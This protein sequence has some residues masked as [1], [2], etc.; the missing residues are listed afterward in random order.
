MAVGIT[1]DKKLNYTAGLDIQEALK[2]AKILKKELAE[3]GVGMAPNFKASQLALQDALKRS[4]LELQELKK[5]EQELKNTRAQS[6]A[7]NAEITKKINEN[8]LA[9]QQLTAAARAA[10]TA[11]VAVSGSYKEA[12]ERL[13]AL[14]KEIRNTT[15]GFNSQ[16]PALKAKVKEYNELNTR[17]KAF[18]TQL[19]NHQRNVGNYGGALKGALG[20]LTALASGYIAI[21]AI[22]QKSFTTS[23]KLDSI[24]KSLE[25]TFGSADLA[26]QR[27][28]VLRS[29]AERL[30]LEY[31]SLADTYRS[32]AGAAKASNFPMEEADK[33]FNAVA[34]AGAKLSLSSDEVKGS[35][36]ALQQMISKGNVQAEELRG[37]LGE[38]LP[39]AFSIAARSMGV[40]EQELGKLLEKGEVLAADL[41]PK[42]ADELNKTFGADQNQRIETLQSSV[43]RLENTFSAA[44]ESGNIGSFFKA[45]VDGATTSVVF[46][47]KLISKIRE[48]SYDKAI[49]NLQ[50]YQA[51][52]GNTPAPFLATKTGNILISEEAALEEIASRKQEKQLENR[53]KLMKIG[54]QLAHDIIIDN[55]VTAETIASLTREQQKLANIEQKRREAIKDKD[56]KSINQY[57]AALIQQKE[58]VKALEKEYAKPK[59]II[60]EA[61]QKKLDAAAKRIADRLAKDREK[62]LAEAKKFQEEVGK[63]EEEQ[64]KATLSAREKEEYEINKKYADLLSREQNTAMDIL[65]IKEANAKALS[66]M[67][68]KFNEE[69]KKLAKAAGDARFKAYKEDRD[70]YQELLASL[71]GYEEQRKNLVAKYAEQR[72]QLAADG[73]INEIA[74]LDQLEKAALGSLD[75]Q[76]VKKLDAYKAL[77]ADVEGLS[78]AA[79]QKIAAD[80]KSMLDKLVA[81]GKISAEL[82]KEIAEQLNKTT[83][84]LGLRLPDD[85]IRLG[86]ELRNLSGVVGGIDEQ[87]GKVI[88]TIA[89]VIGGVGDFGKQIQGLK[90]IKADDI[91]GQISSTIGL[92][93]TGLRILS[94]VYDTVSGFFSGDTKIEASIIRYKKRVDDLTTSFDILKGRISDS[95]GDDLYANQIEQI[96]ILT[97]KIETLNKAYFAEKGKKNADKG[98]LQGYLDQIRE[99]EQTIKEINAN[100]AQ[101][102]IQTNF[103]DLASTFAESL[104]TAYERIGNAFRSAGD[105]I[106]E[107]DEAFDKMVQSAIKNSLKMQILEPVVARFTAAL[108]DYA[109]ANN[110]S[111][112]GFD[113]EEWQ[114][115]LRF[116]GAQ[117]S[118]ALGASGKFFGVATADGPDKFLKDLGDKYLKSLENSDLAKRVEEYNKRV[119][120]A[121]TKG[122]SATD[123]EA[124]KKEFD[125]LAAIALQK[126]DE[127]FKLT[128]Q[129]IEIDPLTL[130]VSVEKIDTSAFDNDVKAIKDKLL[131]LALDSQDIFKDVNNS[132][133]DQLKNNFLA[134]LETGEY[135][136]AAKAYQKRFNELATIGFTTADVSSLKA[137][138]DAL[139]AL[140]QEKIKEYEKVTGQKIT[141]EITTPGP[142]IVE[143]DVQAKDLGSKLFALITKSAEETG[144]AIEDILKQSI[145]EGLQSKIITD[146]LKPLAEKVKGLYA[147][148]KTP[149]KD[150]IAALTAEMTTFVDGAKAQLKTLQEVTGLTFG[151]AVK[152]QIEEAAKVV[153]TELKSF[154]D[155]MINMFSNVEGGMSEFEANWDRMVQNTILKKLQTSSLEDKL[156]DFYENFNKLNGVEDSKKAEQLALLKAQYDRII[157]DGQ[158]EYE[159]LQ[160][161]FGVVAPTKPQDQSAISSSIGR[162]ITEDTANVLSGTFLGI[163]DEV[164]RSSGWLGKIYS[165]STQ[166]LTIQAAIEAGVRRTANNT[167]NLDAKLDAIER[168]TRPK[169]STNLTDAYLKL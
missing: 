144:A 42:L 9:Q 13:T 33:I 22:L 104:V 12:Q 15:N 58:I 126:Q 130:T 121:T 20:Q 28:D 39:G 109:R 145:L 168:N 91:F 120:E 169:S 76:N 124:F 36:L 70:K 149:T 128:G 72:A 77:Y 158:A 92:V 135:A 110:N 106:K 47:E 48:T 55:K 125:D 152:E 150:E 80:G 37:Q 27:M 26:A 119:A 99:A 148:G 44:V 35:L 83:S 155:S 123:V 100:I 136:D 134:S 116:A 105:P 165:I 45:I 139:A 2:Q 64:F 57:N 78:K 10:R 164:K 49:N 81:S 85:L 140:A 34:N 113:F 43:N 46:I 16:T 87:F 97:S 115:Q 166:N 65:R 69:D 162:S 103:K 157:R 141:P 88:G 114:R 84:V 7:D 167:D 112:L 11:N 153:D 98:A 156:T 60:S 29:T 101:G 82:A 50:K 86:S 90:K 67:N 96:Q 17:L 52:N 154:Q 107:F 93:T 147:N 79:V 21:G 117:F 1:S 71:A 63:I 66:L 62:E 51:K 129:K 95:I 68:D 54:Q 146:T 38:R 23:I 102:L 25:F 75:D 8:R 138:Y 131:Q 160:D 89:D 132:F 5:A 6:I 40:T 74:V 143:V 142:V 133:T 3:L 41:L 30:G 161:V 118:T 122:L 151:E 18:D 4:R 127:F 59:K 111:V 159:R 24:T 19:G 53:N 73:K 61:E 94:S 56:Q 32:F 137:Q 14:G 31:I 163:Y 108:A